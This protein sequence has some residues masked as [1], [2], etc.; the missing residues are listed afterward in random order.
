MLGRRMS[1][2]A[3]ATAALTAALVAGSWLAPAT[4]AA[5][6]HVHADNA[7]RG[8]TALI[9]FQV[10]NESE[11]GSPTTQ[12]T[13]TL[14]DVAS[15]STDVM[16]GWTAALDRDAGSGKYRSVTFTASPDAGIGAAQF[17]LFTVSVKL[18]DADSVMFPVTQTYA[19][20]AVVHWDQPPL[21]NGEEPEY[22]APLLTLTAGPPPAKEH[23]AA[24]AAPPPTTTPSVSTAPPTEEHAQPTAGPDNTARALAGGALL[25]AAIGVGVALAR[26]RT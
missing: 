26:R 8:Q 18:P 7:L 4:A 12:V 21:P 10:P 1:G 11:T 2:R 5:H 16:P 22:P 3:R 15:A 24:P 13:I 19:D 6:V 17:E 20:G 25:V 9:T 14:P 23:H